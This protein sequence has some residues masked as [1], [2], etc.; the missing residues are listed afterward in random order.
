MAAGTQRRVALGTIVCN[1]GE[2]VALGQEIMGS[3][4]GQNKG[5]HSQLKLGG[6]SVVSCC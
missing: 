3:T 2:S 1:K 6:L 4:G 5:V